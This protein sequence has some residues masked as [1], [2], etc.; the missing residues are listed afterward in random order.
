MTLSELHRMPTSPEYLNSQ[1]TLTS[2]EVHRRERLADLDDLTPSE[3]LPF[4]ED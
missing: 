2:D 3:R 4:T 1:R